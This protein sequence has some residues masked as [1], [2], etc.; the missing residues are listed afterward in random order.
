MADKKNDSVDGG[1][2]SKAQKEGLK[3]LL[4]GGK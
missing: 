4:K 3:K 1:K 2:L